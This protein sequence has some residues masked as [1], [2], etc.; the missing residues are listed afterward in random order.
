M[1]LMIFQEV[2]N[3]EDEVQNVFKSFDKR[4]DFEKY[5]DSDCDCELLFNIQFTGNVKLKAIK[6]I[7]PEDDSHPKKMLLFKVKEHFI[8]AILILTV[9]LF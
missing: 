5:V 1:I 8:N 6:I 4:L 3:S 7:A 9:L 2:L